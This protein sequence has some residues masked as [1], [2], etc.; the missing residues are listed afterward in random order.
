MVLIRFHTAHTAEELQSGVPET[1]LTGQT[2]DIINIC[3][4]DWYE[5]VMFRD[6]RASYTEE[7]QTLGRYLGPI[8]SKLRR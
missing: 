7:K 8:H 1:I 4:Y 3:E 2:A 6:N 5:W